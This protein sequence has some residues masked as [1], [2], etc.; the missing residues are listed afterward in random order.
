[1]GQW[2]KTYLKPKTKNLGV[3]LYLESESLYLQE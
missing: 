2:Q 3:I 1:M